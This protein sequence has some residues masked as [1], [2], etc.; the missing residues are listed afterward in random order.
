MHPDAVAALTGANGDSERSVTLDTLR[1]TLR[2]LESHPAWNVRHAL[3]RATDTV[4]LCPRCVPC[5]AAGVA[6]E[7]AR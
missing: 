5:G 3:A 4:C 6:R 1:T 2:L 7:A